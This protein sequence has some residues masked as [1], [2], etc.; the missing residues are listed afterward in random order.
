ME[1]LEGARETAE[2]D[3]YVVAINCGERDTCQPF[4]W[5]IAMK[6]T[7]FQGLEDLWKPAEELA[8]YRFLKE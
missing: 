7:S 8:M 3:D 6:K 5:L 1:D 4:H 2:G